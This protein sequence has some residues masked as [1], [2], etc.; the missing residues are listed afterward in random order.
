MT[1]GLLTCP[2]ITKAGDV[3]TEVS[4]VLVVDAGGL[5]ER[6]AEGVVKIRRVIAVEGYQGNAVCGIET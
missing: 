1:I 2:P 5:G 3:K 4:A 6:I